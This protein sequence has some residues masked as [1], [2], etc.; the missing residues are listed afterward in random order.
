MSYVGPDVNK[1]AEYQCAGGSYSNLQNKYFKLFPLTTTSNDMPEI[2]VGSFVRLASGKVASGSDSNVPLVEKVADKLPDSSEDYY[3]KA[4]KAIKE[5]VEEIDGEKASNMIIS[6]AAGGSRK[7]EKI[8]RYLLDMAENMDGVKETM[9]DAIN[10]AEGCANVIERMVYSVS[11][12]GECN[13]F[14]E[15]NPYFKVSEGLS[16]LLTKDLDFILSNPKVADAYLEPLLGFYYFMITIQSTMTLKKKMDGD[17]SKIAELY[18]ALDWEKTNLNRPCSTKGFK[19][20]EPAIEEMFVHAGVLEIL[21]TYGVCKQKEQYDYIKIKESVEND[22]LN[23]EALFENICEATK[24]IRSVADITYS[25]GEMRD[26]ADAIA[27]CSQVTI[28]SSNGDE[29]CDVARAIEYL[30]STVHDIIHKTDRDAARRRYSNSFRSF[31]R[32]PLAFE[33]NRG[34]GGTMLNITEEVLLCLTVVAIGDKEYLRLADVFKQ[35]ECRGVFFDGI[36]KDNVVKFYEKR[37]M[38]DK[39]SDSGE[40]Q[41]VKRVI[42]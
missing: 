40:A 26:V 35:F 38:L 2:D 13:R 23:R 42:L 37:N 31:C 10:K 20:L 8:A 6:F 33:K 16:R 29:E 4:I 30:Y 18:F 12:L 3:E 11:S 32:G 24:K 27:T 7:S 28:N 36:S 39:K 5:A 25:Y 19:T 17:R 41:Y 15:E 21:N 14:K 22:S 1:I 34:R 9:N